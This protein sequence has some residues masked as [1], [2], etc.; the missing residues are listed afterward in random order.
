MA[1][2]DLMLT[3]RCSEPAGLP[4]NLLDVHRRVAAIDFDS[5]AKPVTTTGRADDWLLFFS[6]AQG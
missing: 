5:Q 1:L 3:K 2:P 6:P 4:G